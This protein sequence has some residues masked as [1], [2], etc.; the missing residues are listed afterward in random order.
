LDSLV[1]SKNVMNLLDDKKAEKSGKN[2]PEKR[3][4]EVC[5]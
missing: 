1:L 3:P 5:P 2:M 4:E